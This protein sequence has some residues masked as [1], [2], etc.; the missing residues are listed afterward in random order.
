[1]ESAFKCYRLTF[2]FY[3]GPWEGP[4]TSLS[5][6]QSVP[7]S[8]EWPC[9]QH[10]FIY[11]LFLSFPLSLSLPFQALLHGTDTAKSGGGRGLLH[12]V[13]FVVRKIILWFEGLLS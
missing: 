12:K 3:S 9:R 8:G 6:S 4:S 7:L 5:L 1:M 2:L 11:P 10:A 13:F